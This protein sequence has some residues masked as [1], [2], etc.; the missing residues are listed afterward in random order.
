M[1]NQQAFKDSV[2]RI[3]D[4]VRNTYGGQFRQ[5]YEGDPIQISD[6]NLPCVVVEKIS[7]NVQLD[8]TSTDLITEQIM[9]KLVFNKR[10]DLGA[11]NDVDFTE[12]RLRLMVEGRDPTTG[13][14]VPTSLMYILR[15]NITLGG[16]VIDS[17]IDVNYDV[18][19]RPEEMFTSEAQIMITITERVIIPNRV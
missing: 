2:N 17:S 9:I 11:A 8:A 6:I 3:L 16:A 1:D 15:T 19:P 10:D 4:L 13:Y 5:F 12:R 18:N 14:F 7:G